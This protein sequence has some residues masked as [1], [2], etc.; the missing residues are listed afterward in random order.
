MEKRNMFR[1]CTVCKDGYD[2]STLN[3]S[4]VDSFCPTCVKEIT[5]PGL[6]LIVK[7]RDWANKQVDKQGR[8]ISMADVKGIVLSVFL[9]IKYKAPREPLYDSLV[10]FTWDNIGDAITLSELLEELSTLQENKL[11]PLQGNT[12]GSHNNS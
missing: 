11:K 12:D 1:E 5:E 4:L 10:K 3:Y 7:F 2:V 9:A 8:S 6:N